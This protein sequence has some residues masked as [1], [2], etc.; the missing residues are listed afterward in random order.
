MKKVF[1][2]ICLILLMALFAGFTYEGELD[3]N[4]F[5]KWQ[6]VKFQ[7]TP[8][9]LIWVFI[10]N[11]DQESPIKIVA[12]IAGPNLTLIGYRYFKNGEPYMYKLD[13]EQSKYVRMELSEERRRRCME[14]HSDQLVPAAAI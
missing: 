3:P 7:P 4:E 6:V 13:P 8:Q 10:R 9:G 14:Y 2:L 1:S 12:Q 5:D 11:P